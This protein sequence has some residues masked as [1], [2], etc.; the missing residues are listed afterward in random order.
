M[1]SQIEILEGQGNGTDANPFS[2]LI[3]PARPEINVAG[4]EFL[5]YDGK[6]EYGD[7]V[8]IWRAE[9]TV[10]ERDAQHYQAY[11]VE[12]NCIDFKVPSISHHQHYRQLLNKRLYDLEGK[13]PVP[14]GF[15]DAKRQQDISRS[16]DPDRQVR[17]SCLHSWMVDAHC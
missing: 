6:T 7:T 8:K 1:P 4:I 9:I 5:A 14:D 3:D 11:V 13:M 10:Y 2:M 16:N 17:P 15:E 12:R